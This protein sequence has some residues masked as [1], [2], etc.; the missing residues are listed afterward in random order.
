[1]RGNLEKILE[2]SRRLI[3]E[4]RIASSKISEENYPFIQKDS[5]KKFLRR[6]NE[7]EYAVQF[8]VE[9][10]VKEP[11]KEYALETLRRLKE[12]GCTY[13]Y[14]GIES[15]DDQVMKNV[16][17][18]RQSQNNI[19]HNWFEK[20]NCALELFQEAELRVGASLLFGI[21]GETYT[22][23]DNTINRTK[24]LLAENKLYLV[25][26]NLCSYHPGTQLTK[27]DCVINNLDYVNIPKVEDSL[28]TFFEEAS[29]GHLSKTLNRE[30]VEYIRNRLGELKNLNLN[31]IKDTQ[32]GKR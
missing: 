9:D 2:F 5:D 3:G 20:V 8:C 31:T 25:S 22:T 30:M 28:M 26:P 11:N 4:K 21:P 19:Y 12:S 29:E 7:F 17:K 13:I 32:N 10:I 1:M 14:T 15:L 27:T 6:L 23:I 16:Q 18:F 24:T